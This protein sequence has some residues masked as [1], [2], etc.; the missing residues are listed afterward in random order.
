MATHYQ[1]L[2]TFFQ[3]RFG[4]RVHKITV[5]AGLTCPNR[6]GRIAPD[7]CIYCNPKGSGTGA[8]ARGLSI[9][10][11]LEKSKAAVVKRFKARKFIAYFQAFSNTYAPIPILKSLYDEAL[12]V[13]GVVGLAIGTRPDCA[14]EAVLDL[15]QNYV[16]EYMVWIEYGLQ[17]AHDDTLKRIRRGHNFRCFEEAVARTRDRGI[18]TCAHVILGLPGETRDHMMKT[19]DRLADLCVDAVKLHL[20]YVIRGTEMEKMLAQGKYRCLEQK[21][22]AELVCDFI[23][24][25]PPETVIQRLTGDP[26]PAELIA[27]AWALQKRETLAIIQKTFSDRKSCQGIRIGRPLLA[28]EPTGTS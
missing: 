6:D 23:E 24:R 11:Q 2:N 5:D 15:I 28:A 9:T 17:S 22:Y 14:D 13:K 25:L 27:P 18:L 10:Q 8:H 21:E 12:S 20:L 1:D 4:C 26:H 7:G 16:R 19:A 3:R